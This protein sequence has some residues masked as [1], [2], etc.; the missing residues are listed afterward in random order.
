[1]ALILNTESPQDPTI[2]GAVCDRCKAQVRDDIALGEV[3]HVRMH[4]GCGSEWG[5]G[6]VVEADLCDACCSELLRPFARVFPSSELYA[7]HVAHGLNPHFIQI[8]ALFSP[9]A[10]HE[11]ADAS[12]KA[13]R[14][15]GSEVVAW[16]TYS[17]LLYLVPAK[18]LLRPVW[19]AFV[20]LHAAIEVEERILRRVYCVQTED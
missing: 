3:L 8:G 9:S 4:A 16:I 11:D 20:S 18:V 14:S 2:I 7:G 13:P 17:F 5:D 6:N 15:L 19:K 1:M 12:T 10:L